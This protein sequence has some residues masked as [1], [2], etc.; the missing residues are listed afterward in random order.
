MVDHVLQIRGEALAINGNGSHGYEDEAEEG[1]Q[2][3]LSWAE[4]MAEEPL[5]P[6]RRRKAQ[7]PA[8]SLFKWALEQER[9]PVGAGR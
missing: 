1:Q 3:L 7:A 4:F 6:K 5:K 2:S 8:L 9:A